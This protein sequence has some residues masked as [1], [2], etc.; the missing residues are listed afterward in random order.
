MAG[1][2]GLNRQFAH[3]GVNGHRGGCEVDGR[4]Y[5]E[6]LIADSLGAGRGQPELGRQ[7]SFNRFEI[8]GVAIGL[9]AAGALTQEE[10]E[11]ILAD[12]DVTLQRSGRLKVV[13][14]EASASA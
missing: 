13:R 9:A 5:L 8:R 1:G 10:A 6:K 3:C 4:G 11:Q 2:G 14:A 7:S 12:L